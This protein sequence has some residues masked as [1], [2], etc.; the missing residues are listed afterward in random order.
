MTFPP[1][2]QYPCPTLPRRFSTA[3][4]A[5]AALIVAAVIVGCASLPANTG[6]VASQSF[7]SPGQT[8]LGQLTAQRRVQAGARSDSAFSLLENVDNALAARLALV[9]AAQKTLDLQ[10]Y[11]IH[12][13]ASTELILQHLRDAAR[14]GVR[15][16]LLLDDFNAVGKDAQVLRLA[17]EPNVQIRLFN[18]LPGSRSSLVVRIF[19][20]LKDVDRIQKRM[21]NKLFIADNA[22]AIS[23]GRNLGDAY[24][25]GPGGSNFVDLDTLSAGRIV[26]DMSASFDRYWNDEL[27][28]PMEKLVTQQELDQMRSAPVASAPDA[29][30]QG[31]GTAPAVPVVAT[32]TSAVMPDVTRAAVADAKPAGYDL[33][34]VPLVWA[35]SILL[36]DKPGKIGPD[37]DEADAGDTVVDGLLALMNQA[38]QDVLI[39]SPYFVP[40]AEMMKVFAQIRAKGV[41][42]RVLTNSLASND[43]PA[44]HAGYARYREAL[45]ALGVELYEMRADQE[46]TAAGIGSGIGSAGGSK[47]GVSHASLHSKAA[48]ID[49]RLA[50]IGSMNLDLRS[51]RQN[52]EVAL[53]IRSAAVSR[54]AARQIETTLAQGAYRVAVENGSLVWRAPPGAAFKDTTSEPQATARQRLL[55]RL[56]APF[57]PDEML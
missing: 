23:G 27:S 17:F 5:L 49:S 33:R 52:S 43:A 41:R 46:G 55:M 6:R 13:D 3:W 15:V 16:R 37:D 48:I 26:R 8:A 30:Q 31:K 36:V 45:I 10:Y 2:L 44:A 35:P 39:V 1:D 54:L 57:A 20:S 14:R 9:D 19:T 24:F 21:H 40:G 38:R 11:A 51:Q 12:A 34:S 56:I 25:G 22:M 47:S 7:Q 18:P 53:L 4:S 29:S 50:V 42:I 32:N 28:F